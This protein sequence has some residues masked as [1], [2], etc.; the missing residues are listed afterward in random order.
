MFESFLQRFLENLFQR[1]TPFYLEI[2][3]KSNHEKIW[4]ALTS[5]GL[6]S[7]SLSNWIDDNN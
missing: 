6:I 4:V 3:C 1:L 2:S 5:H 7:L